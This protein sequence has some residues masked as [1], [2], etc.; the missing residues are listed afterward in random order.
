MKVLHLFPVHEI[1]GAESVLLNLMRFRRRTDIAHE[2]LL[3]ANE[4]GALGAE[5]TKMGTPWKRIPRGRMR[6]PRALWTACAGVRQQVISRAPDVL[7]SNSAQGFLYGRLATIGS[8]L[9]GALYQM[10]VPDISG[11]RNGPLDWLTS[12]VEPDLIFAASNVIRERVA[13]WSRRPVQTVYHGTPIRS[14]DADKIARVDHTL[15]EHGVPRHAP[16]VL[17]PGR[18]QAWKGQRLFVQA[19][20]DVHATHPEAHA[21]CLGSALFGL[22]PEY[23]QQLAEDVRTRG[24]ESHVHLIPHQS[25]A[26][27]LDRATIVVHASLTADAFPNVCIEALASKRALVTNN[28]AGTSEVLDN[29]RDAIVVR[30]GDAGALASAIRDLIENPT[31][32]QQMAEAG[33]RTYLRTCTPEQMVDAIEAALID[34]VAEG[35]GTRTRKAAKR[36]EA[37]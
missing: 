2:A 24:L 36:P 8:G 26:P 30:A 20:S 7:L 3:I 27:W 19:F 16:V 35:S 10:S 13:N 12:V 29:G 6:N 31:R 9:P 21:V 28:L 1:G 15:A 4:D 32:R 17:M 37:A 18:L 11:W 34:L 23:P 5:L 22:E 25:I 14:G 33:Y